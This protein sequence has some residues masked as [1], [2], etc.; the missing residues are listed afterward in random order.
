MIVIAKHFYNSGGNML[1]RIEL[2]YHRF[3]SVVNCVSHVL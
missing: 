2:L 1:V 3:E